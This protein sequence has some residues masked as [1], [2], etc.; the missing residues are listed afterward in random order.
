MTGFEVRAIPPEMLTMPDPCLLRRLIGTN[1][2]ALI[3]ERTAAAMATATQRPV[4]A[5]ATAAEAGM[6]YLQQAITDAGN[7]TRK[8]MGM[9]EIE[10]ETPE[11]LP[12]I[13]EP[14]EN[15]AGAIALW[16]TC[17]DCGGG[18]GPGPKLCAPIEGIVT[19]DY[20]INML[21]PE[22]P[23]TTSEQR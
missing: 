10:Q 20:K 23:H 7:V 9:P 4:L 5:W 1:A 14:D 22:T 8:A 11:P 3:R 18:V 16:R 13:I 15:L 12:N 19:R 2:L 6:K 21:N 17:T